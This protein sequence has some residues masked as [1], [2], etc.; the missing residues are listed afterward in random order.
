MAPE[1]QDQL[2]IA[3]QIA[4]LGQVPATL[5]S[6]SLAIKEKTLTFRAILESGASEE[7]KE[8]LSCAASEILA[9]LVSDFMIEEQV[10][11]FDGSLK[12]MELSLVVFQRK[13]GG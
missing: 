8:S 4:L 12:E 6:V 11:C 5:R 10:F 3:S 7:D 1:D 9:S 2:R 13:E